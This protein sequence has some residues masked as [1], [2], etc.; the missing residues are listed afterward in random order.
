MDTRE[1]LTFIT[2]SETLNYQKA[3]DRLQ[4]A[5]STLFKHIQ[6]LESELGSPLIV[7]EGRALRL[8]S[9][10][11]RFLPHAHRILVEYHAALGLREEQT[12]TLNIGGCEMNISNSLIDL[13]SRFAAIHPHIRINMMTAPNASV[14]EMVREEQVDMGFFYSTG[15]KHHD[16]RVVRLYREPAF[17]VASR[18]NPLAQARDLHYEDLNGMEFVYPHDSCCFVTMLMPELARRNVTLKRVTYLGGMQL[19]VEQARRDGTVTIAPQCALPRFE[20]TYGLVRLDIQEEPI[21]A[22][23]TILLG[24]HANMP[25]VQELLRFSLREAQRI[26]RENM[27]EADEA[28]EES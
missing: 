2:V 21:C 12:C 17:L 1:L 14:P 6:Q 25:A 24:K 5:P 10:G 11:E 20:E 28:A 19:V 16:L 13:L 18:Q 26:I 22:W 8:T 4:Y 23:E 9:A 7:R 27:L 15:R 3:A